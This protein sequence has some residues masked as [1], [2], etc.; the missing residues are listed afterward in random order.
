[1]ISAHR[2]H[3]ALGLCAAALVTGALLTGVSF[4]ESRRQEELAF[5]K[6]LTIAS[7]NRVTAIRRELE[8]NLVALHALRA[9]L[10]ISPLE[11]ANFAGFSERLMAAHSSVRS[12]EWIPRVDRS[13]RARFETGLG[14]H[15]IFEG[16]PVKLRRAADRPYYLP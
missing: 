12:L 1:M 15:Y 14:G 5:H 7:E 9:Y 3:S 2:K 13:D 4:H 8:A 6:D 11:E 10:E 16:D